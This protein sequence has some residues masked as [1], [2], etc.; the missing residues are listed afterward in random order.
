MEVESSNPCCWKALRCRR[1]PCARAL[2]KVMVSSCE[3]GDL[4]MLGIGGFTPLD[5]FMSHADWKSVC[6]DLHLA[7]GLFWPIPITL[8]TSKLAAGS[9]KPNSDVA[10]VE[11]H[12]SGIHPF[13]ITIDREAREYLPRMY[14]AVNYTVIDDVARLPLKVSG[15][16]PAVDDIARFQHSAITKGFTT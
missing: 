2:P 4:I 11:A 13:Y 5:G 15:H 8:S 6:D 16:L 9:I 7:N 3:R 12:R 14:G 1:K 10:L